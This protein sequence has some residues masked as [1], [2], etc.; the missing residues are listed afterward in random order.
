MALF[1]LVCTSFKSPS[2]LSVAIEILKERERERERPGGLVFGCVIFL[3]GKMPAL[4]GF[5][6]EHS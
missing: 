4:I 6:E 3:F 2:P 5:L 1:G